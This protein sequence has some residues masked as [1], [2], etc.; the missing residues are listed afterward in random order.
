MYIFRIRINYVVCSDILKREYGIS[1]SFDIAAID[2]NFAAPDKIC[3]LYDY[4]GLS[5]EKLA[6]S[7]LK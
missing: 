3:N 5:A 1:A 2:D 7:I 6:E 4:V